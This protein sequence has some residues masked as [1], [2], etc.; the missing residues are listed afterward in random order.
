MRRIQIVG[1]ALL[2]AVPFIANA[3]DHI[4]SPSATAEPGADITDV[5]AWMSGDASK[6]NMVLDVH[7]MAS[8]DS[9]FSPAVQYALHINSAAAFGASESSEARI[10]CQFYTP[11]AIE[12]WLGDEYLEGDPSDPEGI[13]SESGKL[14][15]F[16]GRRDDPFFFELA[17]FKE[18]VKTVTSVAS[19]LTFDE[20]GCPAVDGRRDLGGA[21]R[22]AAERPR[23]CGREQLVRGQQRPCDRG[24][25]GQVARDHGRARARSLGEHARRQLSASDRRKRGTP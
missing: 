16:A 6:V 2:S 8:A 24:A 14:R 3:A 4:D 1:V 23:G 7:H 17:G 22:S 21:G 10:L 20:E 18:T 25:G 19:G 5:Y 12:C 9:A 13:V 11:S 15:V